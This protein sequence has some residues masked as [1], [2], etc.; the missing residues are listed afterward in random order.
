MGGNEPKEGN[1]G[2]YSSF[3]Q[4]V[5]TEAI[6]RGMHVLDAEVTSD[7]TRTIEKAQRYADNHFSG[8]LEDN[9]SEG[10]FTQHFKVGHDSNPW[11]G[12]LASGKAPEDYVKKHFSTF[13]FEK[14]Y[15]GENGIPPERCRVVLAE[16]PNKLNGDTRSYG[17]CVSFAPEDGNGSPG[18]RA[19]EEFC[20]S[21]P[22]EKI[23]IQTL[24]RFLT[25]EIDRLMA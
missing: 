1:A 15:P 7:V 17:V 9:D 16:V 23:E 3:R 12:T 13:I 10:D 22:V 21:E 25:E 19:A 8:H 11:D 6:R 14:K 20:L 4:Y 2:M 24:I 18:K 5:L